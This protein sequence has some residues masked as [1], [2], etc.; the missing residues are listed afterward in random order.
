MATLSGK[1][2]HFQFFKQNSIMLLQYNVF[3]FLALIQSR[4]MFIFLIHPFSL[5]LIRSP[6]HNFVSLSLWSFLVERGHTTGSLPPFDK[7]QDRFVNK[8]TIKRPSLLLIKKRLRWTQSIYLL[9]SSSSIEQLFS[10]LSATFYETL[11]NTVT[12]N[13]L[14]RVHIIQTYHTHTNKHLVLFLLLFKQTLSHKFAKKQTNKQTYND[15]A[16]LSCF[17]CCLFNILAP[18]LYLILYSIDFFL[19]PSIVETQFFCFDS[20]IRSYDVVLNPQIL[21]RFF[22]VQLTFF[23]LTLTFSLSYFSSST[24]NTYLRKEGSRLNGHSVQR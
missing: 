24:A 13:L 17:N 3:A 12:Q 2:L 15:F 22:V 1:N 5:F 10:A 9:S 18:V 7:K 11:W 23:S 20:F 16:A 21:F 19:S 8:Q 14:K 4:K 6:G